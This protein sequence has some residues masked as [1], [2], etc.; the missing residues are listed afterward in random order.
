V[1]RR[2]RRVRALSRSS[3]VILCLAG[4]GC[5]SDL[6]DFEQLPED[7]IAVQFWAG[8]VGRQREELL[9]E[10]EGKAQPSR[11]QG[12]VDLGD[13]ASRAE[14][15]AANANDPSVRF[16]GRIALINPRT[17][18]VVFPDE[19]PPGARPVSWSPDRTRLM[20]SSDRQAGRYQ[21]YEL[22]V[23]KRE[24]RPVANG[25]E[26]ILA[27]THCG[28]DAV[29]YGA[30]QLREDGE[31]EME[32]R[33]RVPRQPDRVLAR[34]V[35]VR[36]IAASR[37]GRFVAYAPHD[38]CGLA[39]GAKRLPRI[40]V[41]DLELGTR[42]EL[43]PGIHPVFTP[44]G[45]WVVYSARHGDGLR[46]VRVRVGG[47]GRT[48]VG[49]ALRNEETP[50]VSPDGDY[51]VYVSRHNGLDRLFVK[52]FDGTGDRLLYDGAAVEWPVW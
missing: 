31:V 30:I 51:V 5:V 20:F 15:I 18:D 42:R 37:D 17:R 3:G 10:R 47:T 40:V 19:T 33:T 11:R 8:E 38:L 13:V 27:G 2:C 48:A 26:T 35:A 44:D 50:A 43:G 45:Q 1:I 36:H 21:L 46:T 23:V 39:S 12:V 22:D 34:D 25:R 32:I 29:S 49:P 4:L 52:R 28:Q 9:S 7:A 24:V 14:G 6:V 41:E 16:P